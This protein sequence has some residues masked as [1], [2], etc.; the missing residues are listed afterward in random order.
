ME[1]CTKPRHGHSVCCLSENLLIVT[2]SRID[3]DNAP[4]SVEAY[5]IDLDMWFDFPNLNFGRHYHSSCV[6]SEQW[7]YVFAGI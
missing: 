6:L 1:P 4:N 7:I 5:N 3:I 2:G